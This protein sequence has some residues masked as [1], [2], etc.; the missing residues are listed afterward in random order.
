MKEVIFHFFPSARFLGLSLKILFHKNKEIERMLSKKMAF[1][2][3]SLITLLALAFVAPTAMAGEFGVALDMTKDVSTAGNLQLDHP[4][5]ALPL[6]VRFD[7]AVVLAATNI[8]VS[9]FDKDGIYIPTVALAATTPI[10]P[11][12]AATVIT[13]NITITDATK[14]V[15]FKIPKGIA[16]ADPFNAD[17]S[18]ELNQ[19]ITLLAADEGEPRVISIERTDNPLLP[20][21]AATVQVIITLSEQAKAFT[22]DHVDVTEAT[23]ADPVALDPIAE[24]PARFQKLADQIAATPGLIAPR[25]LR[26]LYNTGDEDNPVLGIHAAIVA[27]ADTVATKKALVDALAAYNTALDGNNPLVLDTQ[28]AVAEQLDY[29]RFQYIGLSKRIL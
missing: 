21:T 5:T 14:T 25:A 9:G 13:V 28:L 19:V 6:T 23:W 22:K 17:T 2:L 3:M 20:V 4:G 27:A 26:G 11:A 8:E 12:T 24:D 10:V 15:N 7:R 29:I 1:S 16:S 18:A